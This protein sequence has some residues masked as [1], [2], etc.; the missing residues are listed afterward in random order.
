M[1]G[2]LLRLRQNLRYDHHS[3]LEPHL[4]HPSFSSYVSIEVVEP[5]QQKRMKQPS[6]Q[7]NRKQLSPYLK[8]DPTFT[9]L[10]ITVRFLRS[11]ASHLCRESSGKDPAKPILPE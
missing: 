3:T 2:I 5:H 8:R 1:Y 7:T 6:K 11:P 9:V 4:I 10:P